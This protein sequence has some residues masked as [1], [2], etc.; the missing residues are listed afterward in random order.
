M[1]LSLNDEH[2][3]CYHMDAARSILLGCSHFSSPDMLVAKPWIWA[4]FLFPDYIV[5]TRTFF[6]N[7][8]SSFKR[9]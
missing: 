3:Q 9:C 7:M 1:D 6:V 2:I 5:L 8:E 4:T